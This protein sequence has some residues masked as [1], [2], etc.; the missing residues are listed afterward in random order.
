MI[1]ATFIFFLVTERLFPRREYPPIKFWNLIGFGCL[2]M[3]GALTTFLPMLLPE[4]VTQYHLIDGSRLGIV[5]GVL[6]GYP[7]TALGAAMLHRAFHENNFLWRLG[8]QLHHSPRRL[9]I[10]GSVFFHPVDITLQMAPA[11]LVSIF[12]LGLDPFV[13]G[14]VGYV[15]AFYGMFQHWNVKTPRWLGYIIQRPEA[16]GLHHELGVH[17]RNYS[18]FPLWDMVMGTFHNPET[19]DG[20]VGFAGKAPE[21]VGAMLL[22]QDV[23]AD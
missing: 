11:T 18:D 5:G 21:R 19:F 7:L 15:A 12:V 8:H 6:I 14:C 1:P 3:T 17:A 4:S 2:I 16:H 13:A 9:D 22:F 20:D 10:P 23:N